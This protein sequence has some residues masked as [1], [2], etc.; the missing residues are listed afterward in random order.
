[1][2][3]GVGAPGGEV[4][5]RDAEVMETGD[6]PDRLVEID[7]CRLVGIH[8]EAAVVLTAAGVRPRFAATV[9]AVPRDRVEQRQSNADEKAWAGLANP[10]DEFTE[11]PRPA[12]E[13]TAIPA[14]TA[15]RREELVDEVAVAG[16]E[17]DHVETGGSRIPRGGDVGVEETLDLG[18]GKDTR[19]VERRAVP[20]AQDRVVEGDPWLPWA[21]VGLGE[22]AGVGQLERDE[23]IAVVAMGLPMGGANGVEELAQSLRAERRREE[24]AGIGPPL[25]DHCHRL[26]PPHELG[27]ADP[28]PTPAPQER[29][30]GEAGGGR[31]PALHGVDAPTVPDDSIGDRERIGERGAIGSR[32]NRVVDRQ[33][34]ADRGQMGPERVGGAEA[35]DPGEHR[36]GAPALAGGKSGRWEGGWE[37]SHDTPPPG[38]VPAPDAGPG[39]RR[40]ETA[41]VARGLSMR[42]GGGS[43]RASYRPGV[44]PGIQGIHPLKR[45]LVTGITG[46]DGSYLAEFLLGK[47]YQ[48]HGIVRRSSAV[49]SQRIEHLRGETLG[50]SP[51]LVIHDGDMADGSVLARIVRE[52]RPAE[53]YNLAAQSHVGVSFDQPT[54]TADV[55]ALG[56]LRILEAIR[57]QQ[58]ATG[59]EIRFYQAS[60]SELYGLV[61]STPQD[62]ST[63]FHPRSPYGVAKL[64][65][66]W[67]TINYRESYGLFS[68]C[69]ILF[70]PESPRRG[71]SFVTRKITRAATRIKLGLQ[72]KLQLGNLDARRDWGFAGDYVE[73][74]WLMLQQPK[75]DEYVISTDETHSVR[76]FCEM[77]FARL[78]LDYREHVE[79]DPRYFRPAE[80]DFL[81]GSSAKARR[82][83]GWRPRVGFAELVAMMVDEDL[84]IAEAERDR[85]RRPSA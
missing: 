55:T 74:M 37:E 49:G 83:L 20:G 68:C 62:E 33:P 10:A 30:G 59:E 40:R 17:I 28:E 11:E 54:Y 2:R 45:A 27:A 39:R 32:K 23:E 63:P 35:G 56:A 47:G 76:E 1:M 8:P 12:V 61:A 57:D 77:A 42:E 4:E 82:E 9:D 38:E 75:P 19:G 16:F 44:A 70:N 22:P 67:I 18:V 14:V 7:P 85:P 71:E 34:T 72:E 31:V 73:A 43:F 5:R 52:V 15:S 84:R 58:Q 29:V 36:R 46:Q 80:V 24:L 6:E 50:P 78:G 21:D 48:V 79:V 25:G 41:A 66:H 53:I 65:A 51:R 3:I 60:S 81:R 64:Y 26:S 69:G 13:V